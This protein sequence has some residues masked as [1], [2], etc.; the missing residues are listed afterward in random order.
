M[1]TVPE[2][3][4]WRRCGLWSVSLVPVWLCVSSSSSASSSYT[5][6]TSASDTLHQHTWH[7]TRGAA[8]L[9]THLWPVLVSARSMRSSCGMNSGSSVGP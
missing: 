9:L 3:W 2:S 5:G 4:V 8:Q 1:A 6:N 7:L